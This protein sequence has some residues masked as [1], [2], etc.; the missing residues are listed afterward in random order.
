MLL[1]NS[2]V[3][4]ELRYFRLTVAENPAPKPDH[5]AAGI[6][7]GEEQPSPEQVVPAAVTLAFA[8]QASLNGKLR[9]VAPL[10]QVF[11]EHIP[12][13]GSV[14]ETKALDGSRRQAA[15]FHVLAS[16][17]RFRGACFQQLP[18]VE[19]CRFIQHREQPLAL[20]RGLGVPAALRQV[21]TG[22][23]G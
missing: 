12:A 20:L 9:G 18:V 22:A 4:G 15:R 7:D 1:S 23:L 5:R 6:A 16:G 17:L 21:H 3:C 13:V 10:P 19:G 14:A 2:G 8:Q 11:Q